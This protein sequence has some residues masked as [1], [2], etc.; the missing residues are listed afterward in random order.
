MKVV[1]HPAVQKDISEILQ[2]YDRISPKLGDSFWDEF[3][4][5]VQTATNNPE[6]FALS[7]SPLRRVNLKRFP[8]HFLFR[9]LPGTI[10]IVVLRH[11]R[12]HP[13]HGLK[14]K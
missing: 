2:H 5:C 8:H 13:A 14:R 1:Y 4:L 11:N 9:L 6:H 3:Q 7:I 12:R 10:R